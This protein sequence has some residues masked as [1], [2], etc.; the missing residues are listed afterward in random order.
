MLSRLCSLKQMDLSPIDVTKM[1]RGSRG[2]LRRVLHSRRC[3]CWLWWLSTSP[4]QWSTVIAVII[5]MDTLI[6]QIDAGVK[7]DQKGRRRY[8]SINRANNNYRLT[9]ITLCNLKDTLKSMLPLRTVQR[10]F[11]RSRS[12][13]RNINCDCRVNPE[14]AIYKYKLFHQLYFYF[15]TI[16]ALITVTV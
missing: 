12:S 1:Y 6:E 7:E 5:I 13:M 9:T 15:W 10:S 11:E 4:Q 14:V 16:S 3:C 2:K 8:T